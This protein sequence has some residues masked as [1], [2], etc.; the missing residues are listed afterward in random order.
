MPSTKRIQSPQPL[1]LLCEPVGE[2]ESQVPLPGQKNSHGQ[3]CEDLQHREPEARC[4]NHL[5]PQP[6]GFLGLDASQGSS[7]CCDGLVEI[8]EDPVSRGIDSWSRLVESSPQGSKGP[9][10]PV[11]PPSVS[12]WMDIVTQRSPR[13]ALPAYTPP[14]L[15]FSPSPSIQDATAIQAPPQLSS[16]A[17]LA[18]HQNSCHP[19]QRGLLRKDPWQY[20]P[21]QHPA[22]HQFLQQDPLP[23]GS[24]W[25]KLLQQ[26]PLRQGVLL[27]EPLERTLPLPLR[28][29]QPPHPPSVCPPSPPCLFSQDPLMNLDSPSPPSTLVFPSSYPHLLCPAK[30][31][32]LSTVEMRDVRGVL[33]AQGKHDAQRKT[34]ALPLLG[35]R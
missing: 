19:A 26:N 25:Q 8:P 32:W 3:G 9:Q 34:E 14:P 23:Q 15:A 10:T 20:G 6:D 12:A 31:S 7:Q 2:A 16:S 17:T 18:M 28:T 21:E 11:T 1:A 5:M 35:E 27:P 33:D 30:P 29:A 4:P 13:P 24:L 22:G